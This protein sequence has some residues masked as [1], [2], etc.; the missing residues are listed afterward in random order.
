M[1]RWCRRCECGQKLYEIFGKPAELNVIAIVEF[2]PSPPPRS[3]LSLQNLHECAFLQFQLVRSVRLKGIEHFS[4]DE[5]M[6]VIDFELVQVVRCEAVG[7]GSLL[8]VDMFNVFNILHHF[9]IGHDNIEIWRLTEWTFSGDWGGD[10]WLLSGIM[11]QW[12]DGWVGDFRWI[13]TSYF[14]IVKRWRNVLEN[15]QLCCWEVGS[16]HFDDNF[17]KQLT[18]F[19]WCSSDKFS[20]FSSSTWMP[21]SPELHLSRRWVFVFRRSLLERHTNGPNLI[22]ELNRLLLTRT[23]FVGEKTRWNSPMMLR[24]TRLFS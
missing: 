3:L 18:I 20:S 15:E 13:G 23:R 16:A 1:R 10:N 8:V 22:V 11:W 2:H 5:C 12:L 6:C 14:R 24:F 7:V 9:A 21:E 19:C 17:L 4:V